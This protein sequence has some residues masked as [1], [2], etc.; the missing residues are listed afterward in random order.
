MCGDMSLCLRVLY[1]LLH[2]CKECIAAVSSNIHAEHAV[3]YRLIGS[4]HMLLL[5]LYDMYIH[6]SGQLTAHDPKPPCKA[7]RTHAFGALHT[8][9]IC[10]ASINGLPYDESGSRVNPS[11]SSPC[12]LCTS[13]WIEC[14]AEHVFDPSRDGVW[15]IYGGGC[16]WEEANPI[17]SSRMPQA[18]QDCV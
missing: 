4:V 12:R 3:K 9:I 7:M 15:D 5:A 18:T 10:V 17:D 8:I 14:Y 13:W 6:Q 16:G 11:Y 2:T 1:G